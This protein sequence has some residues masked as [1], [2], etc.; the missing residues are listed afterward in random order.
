MLRRK[1]D[2]H[3]TAEQLQQLL[4]PRDPRLVQVAALLAEHGD[5]AAAIPIMERVRHA[6][7]QSW[8]VNYNLAVAYVQ[9][10]RYDR[11]ADIV[12]PF[13][14][15]QGNAE[16]FDL[17]GA[18]EEKR[19]RSMDAERAFQEAAAR[20]PSNEDYR[21]DYGNSF[22]QHGNVAAAIQVFRAGVADSPRSWKLRAGLGSA[23]Y[24]AA[25]YESAAEALLEAV[26]LKPDSSAAWFLLG[27]AYESAVRSQP[28]I[29]NAFS[30]Y[31]KSAPR[32]PWAYYHYG[33]ILHQRAEA[34]GRADYRDAV[35][36]LN[37]ALRLN[38]KF[39]QP[40]L[41]LGLIAMAE[42]KTEQSIAALQ[43]AVSLEPGLAAAHYRLGLAY[44]R[45]G[46]E[47]QAQQELSRFRALKQDERQ[48]GRVLESL[49]RMA[50]NAPSSEERP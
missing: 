14:R 45:I 49:A 2:A 30:A 32:D 24:L 42:R 28:A 3:R 26:R 12:R 8:E 39:A 18:I 37:Q 20:E 6:F 7:P 46:N 48:R 35:L 44:K 4:Q 36:N 19:G 33:A 11:A 21:F 29:E 25:D 1:G 15:P 23:Y 34:S 50:A 40:Y 10:A 9:T 5:S 17:L 13:T 22:V 41:E 16:A 43:K 47:T 38:A 27:E 31:L